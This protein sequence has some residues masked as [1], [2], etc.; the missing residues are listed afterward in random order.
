MKSHSRNMQ[1]RSNLEGLHLT[2]SHLVSGAGTSSK[3]SSASAHS[4]CKGQQMLRQQVSS[5]PVSHTEQ[6]TVQE[7]VQVS[8]PSHGFMQRWQCQAS[9]H[10]GLVRAATV[11][12]ASSSRPSRLPACVLF[13]SAGALD[14]A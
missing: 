13:Y 5:A 10:V 8:C 1:S 11:Q 2:G 6:H 14:V 4:T 7:G 9:R 12:A 3:L